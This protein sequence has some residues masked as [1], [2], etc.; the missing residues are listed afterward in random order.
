MRSKTRFSSVASR[1]AVCTA[2]LVLCTTAWADDQADRIKALEQQLQTSLQLI[3]K[4]SARVS[5][6]ERAAKPT[7]SAQPAAEGASPATPPAREP[8]HAHMGVERDAAEVG[9]RARESGIPVRGFA[10][11]EAVWSSGDDPARRSGFSVGTL[12][13]YLTPQFSDRVK[14]LFE[15]AFEFEENGAGAADMERVQLGYAFNDDLTLWMGRFHTPFGLWNTLFH[16]GA[17]LQTSIFRPRFIAFEDKDGILPVHAVGVWASGKTRLG[18]QRITYDAYLA[19]G[20]AIRRGR[21]DPNSFTDNDG[22]KMLGFNLGYQPNGRLEGLTVGLHGFGSTVKTFATDGST[23]GSTRLRAAGA[24]YAYDTDHWESI[25]EYYHF[26]NA[27]T[28]G[29]ARHTSNAWFAQVG[30]NIGSLTPFVRF[31]RV[32]LDPADLYFRTQ[33]AGRSYRRASLGARYT[34]D[35]MSSV[36]FELSSTRETPLIQ[37]DES[38]ALVPFAGGSYRR[39]AFQ[40]SIAF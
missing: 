20:S 16:H 35:A 17:N 22:N 28:A 4:L 18:S 21:L 3:E 12:D 36:K 26:A 29:G 30:R 13:L 7:P 33:T 31:E 6:L 11:V 27:P 38:G 34:L 37:I 24:Y 5:E 9:A 8:V 23:L 19:N 39:A 14:A 25:G 10:D 15:I 2:V 32:S 40:Y 1:S